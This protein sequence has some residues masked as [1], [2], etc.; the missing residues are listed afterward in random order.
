[1]FPF[2]HIEK[3]KSNISQSLNKPSPSL[4]KLIN[5]LNNFTEETKDYDE[6]LPNCQH[7]DLGHFQN[8]SEK[9]KTKSLSLLHLNIWSLSKNFDDFCILLQEI[10][11]NFDIIALTES[12]IK[13]NSVSPIN[14]KLENCSI[15]HT[16][17]EIAAGGAL[18]YIIKRL[19]YDP[20]ND[21]NIYTPD[22]LE[23]IFIEIVCPK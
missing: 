3:K 15:E 7:R 6:N 20:R 10:N 1:M 2:C 11:M 13:K 21:L 4:V 9:F 18:L 17:T 22:K 16:P 23:S 14:I 5:Q 8:F 12:R 19:S